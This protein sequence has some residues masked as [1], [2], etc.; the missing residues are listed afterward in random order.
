VIHPAKK[1]LQLAQVYGGRSDFPLRVS[2]RA[3]MGRMYNG[4]AVQKTV[5]RAGQYDATLS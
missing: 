4:P 1:L 5:V 3:Y 2:R